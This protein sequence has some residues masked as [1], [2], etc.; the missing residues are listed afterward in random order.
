M[1]K[2]YSFNKEQLDMAHAY[3]KLEK[4]H[5]ELIVLY[6]GLVQAYR[7]LLKELREL[8]NTTR[9]DVND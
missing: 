4:K 7:S 1:K 3:Y 8:E 5:K 9:A 6:E 2:S